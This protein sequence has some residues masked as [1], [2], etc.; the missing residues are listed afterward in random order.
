MI[1]LR[2]ALREC[3]KE[4]FKHIPMILQMACILFL[5]IVSVSTVVYRFSYFVPYADYWKKDGFLFYSDSVQMNESDFYQDMTGVSDVALSYKYAGEKLNINPP[6]IYSDKLLDRYEPPLRSGKLVLSAPED[7]LPNV[8][9]NESSGYRVG[10]TIPFYQYRYEYAFDE[11]GNV[12][13]S[14]AVEPAESDYQYLR[15]SGV[16]ADNAKL[17]L[18]NG[19]AV[20]SGL[21][22]YRVAYNDI[23]S[24][25]ESEQD[26]GFI[27]VMS[28]SEAKKYWDTQSYSTFGIGM[29]IYEDGLDSSIQRANLETFRAKSLG[30]NW[31]FSNADLY[32]H[33][34]SFCFQQ[35]YTMMPFMI[36]ILILFFLSMISVNS[37][38]AVRKLRTYTIYR[39]CGMSWGKCLSISAC[40]SLF[41]TLAAG[42]LCGLLMLLKTRFHLFSN[43]LVSF[44]WIQGLF[45]LLF[46]LL[47]MCIALIIS[48]IVLRHAQI[49]QLLNET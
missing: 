25:R 8:L 26:T 22:D 23:S 28:E 9:V 3:R 47:N 15:V 10:D 33:S 48:A 2:L 5:T 34:Y 49:N 13:D 29:V 39:V 17:L 43:F 35:V 31:S 16:Y 14:R 36:G 7:P 19:G 40:K 4:W 1:Q 27:A 42:I 20:D 6:L 24:I 30:P 37:V 18:M 21:L 38:S 45:C 12:T 46:L 32:K 11:D 44:G 41:I